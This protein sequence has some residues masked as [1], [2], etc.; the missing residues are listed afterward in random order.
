MNMA[1]L[2]IHV[3]MSHDSSGVKD[4]DR[5]YTIA[6]SRVAREDVIVSKEE[7]GMP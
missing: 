6:A 4:L 7:V 2:A 1:N 3:A 5:E